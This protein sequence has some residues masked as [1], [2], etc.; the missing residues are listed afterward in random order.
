MLVNFI[1]PQTFNVDVYEENTYKIYGGMQRY[2]GGLGIFYT[3]TYSGFDPNGLLEDGY[4]SYFSDPD[5]DVSLHYVYLH[6]LIRHGTSPPTDGSPHIAI[7]TNSG[8]TYYLAECDTGYDEYGNE[9][10]NSDCY[11]VDGSEPESVNPLTY[12]GCCVRTK[13]IRMCENN[14]FGAPYG[15]IPETQIKAYNSTTE[16]WSDCNAGTLK[17]EAAR[18]TDDIF[19]ELRTWT[20]F[21]NAD[22]GFQWFGSFASDPESP[23]ANQISHPSFAPTGEEIAQLAG[24]LPNEAPGGIYTSGQGSEGAIPKSEKITLLSNQEFRKGNRYCSHKPTC[25]HPDMTS[26]QCS[27]NTEE[28]YVTSYGEYTIL[29]STDSNGQLAS[30][31]QFN[32]AYVN[33]NYEEQDIKTIFQTD[34]DD[35]IQ[36]APNNIYGNPCVK[37]S[38]TGV[39]QNGKSFNWDTGESCVSIGSSPSDLGFDLSIPQGFGEVNYIDDDSC[40]GDKPYSGLKPTHG[41]KILKSLPNSNGE[42]WT[43]RSISIYYLSSDGRYMTTGGSVG[44]YELNRKDE[45][46][47]LIA[48]EKSD[49]C[50]NG[51]A[52]SNFVEEI[53]IP[54]DVENPISY[55]IN[56][57]YRY[58]VGGSTTINIDTTG[59]QLGVIEGRITDGYYEYH[60]SVS[61]IESTQSDPLAV[62]EVKSLPARFDSSATWSGIYSTSTPATILLNGDSQNDFMAFIR[63]SSEDNEGNRSTH[64]TGFSMVRTFIGEI[65]FEEIDNSTNWQNYAFDYGS[66]NGLPEGIGQAWGYPSYKTFYGYGFHENYAN[67]SYNPNE[68]IYHEN[69][70]L[71]KEAFHFRFLDFGGYGSQFT[72]DG[73]LSYQNLNTGQ[74]DIDIIYFHPSAPCTSLTNPYFPE[75]GTYCNNSTYYGYIDTTWDGWNSGQGIEKKSDISLDENICDINNPDNIHICTG[76]FNPDNPESYPQ[77]D[78]AGEE[79]NT[80]FGCRDPQ[81]LNYCVPYGCEYGDVSCI[82]PVST[83]GLQIGGNCDV[84]GDG[85][86]N[87]LDIV[88]MINYILGTISLT[89]EQIQ[90][91]DYNG[92]GGINVS[93]VVGCVSDAMGF[94]SNSM[95]N[96]DNRLLN[97]IKSVIQTPNG[98]RKAR[99][100]SIQAGYNTTMIRDEVKKGAIRLKNRRTQNKRLQYHEQ[101][102]NKIKENLMRATKNVRKLRGRR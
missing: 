83:M 24:F 6:D 43:N 71:S 59:F 28:T 9:T 29:E 80:C 12:Q 31:I 96:L 66:G 45:T 52:H 73:P 10:G 17:I 87:V 69:Q 20:L 8:T 74:S 101:K 14:T 26:Y 77:C 44:I 16:T 49:K 50:F 22:G 42:L 33:A 68:P 25:H 36:S 85:G 39:K 57:G 93:D 94:G 88:T 75:L 18:N 86:V 51:S 40:Q 38:G 90:A 11:P 54:D 76:P 64:D 60:D 102:S 72:F 27:G 100:I 55:C 70:W 4:A 89:E 79:I 35:G 81:A 62:G 98:L 21:G 2:D 84:T 23:F 67:G 41:L 34:L 63:H 56:E 47:S 53:T 99:K 3:E 15:A 91:G 46:L 37:L 61:G 95:S 65:G 78:V 82:Y 92:D 30:Q 97:N 5:E 32:E 1:V 19:P 13:Y 7:E 58:Y 48:L